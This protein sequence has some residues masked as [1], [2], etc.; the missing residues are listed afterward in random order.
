MHACIYV[1]V[2]M[3]TY[4]FLP[5]YMYMHKFILIYASTY[6]HVCMPIYIPKCIHSYRIY[7]YMYGYRHRYVHLKWV[8]MYIQNT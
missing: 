2:C 5:A 8:F 4:T 6:T 1:S 3:Y 7:M